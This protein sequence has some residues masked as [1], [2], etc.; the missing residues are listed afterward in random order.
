[1]L[2]LATTLGT[3]ADLALV[4]LGFSLIIFFHELGHFVA[5]RW[6]GIRVLAFAIGF[7]PAMVSYRRG[8]GPRVGSS[9]REYRAMLERAGA[10]PDGPVPAALAG[11]STTEYRWNWL[12]LGGYVK[13]LGQEDADPTARSAAPD[14]YQSVVPWKRMIVISA[15]VVM[16][17][18][19]AAV[20]FVVVF[21]VGL[22]TEAPTVGAVRPG[23]PAAVATARNAQSAGVVGVGLRPRDRIVSLEGSPVDSF[24][25]VAVQVA[26]SRG[27]QA[28]RF[29]VERPGVRE[30]LEFD[31]VAQPDP[32]TRLPSIG[33]GPAA[34]GRL[35]S[36]RNDA[37]REQ[38]R[39]DLKRAGL[40][41]IEPGSE[42]VGVGPATGE[43]PSAD[44]AARLSPY[45]LDDAARASDGRPVVATFA[46]PSGAT[47]RV[48]LIP[49][50]E[51]S[52]QMFQTPSGSRVLV[53]HVAGAVPVM[54]V[55]DVGDPETAASRAGLRK[56]DVFE[57]VGDVE[58]PSVVEGI[59]AIRAAAGREVRVVV[60]RA[61]AGATSTWQSIDLG[62]VPVGR[63]GRIGFS[64]TTTMDDS[65][66]VS[67]WPT[68]R[69]EAP[70]TAKPA[71]SDAP[72]PSLAAPSFDQLAIPRGSTIVALNDTPIASLRE[73]R[74]ALSALARDAAPGQRLDTRLT[75]QRSQAS[76]TPA[77]QPETLTWSLRADEA[78]A[79]RALAWQSPV[80]LWV[81]KPESTLLK[82]SSPSGA[83]FLGLRETHRTMMQT[84]LTFARLFEG[85]VKVEHLKGPVG[86]AH[87]GTIIADRGTIWLLFFM[88]VISIN[89][90][91][92]N[93]LP[94]PI[95]DGGHFLMLLW[96]QLTGRPV[97]VAFQNVA[98]LAGLALFVTL[99]LVVTYNDLSR[100]LGG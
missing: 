90:A 64:P 69:A 67:R 13:M 18:I 14:S 76:A 24:K 97:S 19:V 96:E 89:L 88:G 92:V 55:G 60:Y 74:L 79:L 23:S 2:T 20:L 42:L 49:E 29:V 78:D 15:G 70:S 31:L 5:A 28:L 26:M 63:D 77:A 11:V 81:F 95:V 35:V 71:P 3:L 25:D 7:G 45:A 40:T 91:V 47:T 33:I 22:E 34:S 36:P 59:R 51:F 21:S 94:L 99:F 37:E 30:P 61:Q 72:A 85:T 93:F 75:F 73:L 32:D 46:S 52:A 86:I 68:M 65:P 54:A 17:V 1:M 48:E 6:A 57:L 98:T 4:V 58:W 8:L 9:E 84:Y 62:Q 16:N 50:P 41:I 12:P 56:G 80:P 39:G 53:Q 100:L 27:N 10:R 44:S 83:L 43:Q 82:S 87:V 38:L 66:R